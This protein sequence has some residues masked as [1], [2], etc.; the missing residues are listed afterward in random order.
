MLR[1][2]KCDV[3]LRIIKI[4]ASMIFSGVFDV[5]FLLFR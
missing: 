1:L 3:S 4:I 5:K 2:V